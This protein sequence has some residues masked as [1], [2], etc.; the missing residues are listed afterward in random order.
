[1]K[2]I[3]FLRSYSKLLMVALALFLISLPISCTALEIQTG[4]LSLDL[5][6]EKTWTVDFG[7]GDAESLAK[8]GYP[9]NE[10]AL[11]QSLTLD[12]AGDLTPYLSLSANLNDQNPTYLQHFVLSLDTERWDGLLGDFTVGEAEGFTVYNKK[13][14]GLSLER[15]LEN[16][17]VRAIAS[18]MEGVSKSKVF[19]GRSAEEEVTFSLTESDIDW[20]ERPYLQNIRG[21]KYYP[22]S[23]EYVPQLT[24][25]HLELNANQE[26]WTL[27][28]DWGLAYLK[29]AIQ[30]LPAEQLSADRFEVVSHEGTDFL[31]LMEDTEDLL[32]SR[33][34]SYIEEF[35]RGK[36]SDDQKRYPFHEGTDFEKR[37]LSELEAMAQLE[38]GQQTIPLGDYSQERFYYLGQTD[39]QEDSLMLEVYREGSWYQ[40]S[41]LTDFR[42]ELY[43]E[44]GI[45]LCQF[46]SSFFE[47]LETSKLRAS[48]SY[49]V[50][51]DVFMLGFSVTP[52]SDR[53]YLNDEPLKRDVDYSIDYETGTVILFVEVGSD[54]EVK[55]D[56]EQA[57]GGIGTEAEYQRNFYGVSFSSTP[58]ENLSLSVGLFQA[59]DFAPDPL[60]PEAETMP[61]THT[62]AGLEGTFDSGPW[63]ATFKAGGSINRFPSDDNQRRPAPN[64]INEIISFDHQGRE[65]ILFAHQDGFSVKKPSRWDSYGTADGLAGVSVSDVALAG[66]QLIFATNSG[67]TVVDLQSEAPFARASNWRS[68]YD[69]DGIPDPECLALDAG[70]E[71]LWIGTPSG[72]IKGKISELDNQEEWMRVKREELSDT[73]VT[74]VLASD[75]VIWLGTSRGLYSY[76]PEEDR[77]HRYQAAGSREITDLTKGSG[78]EVYASTARGIV[79]AEAGQDSRWVFTERE[80]T[81]LHLDGDSL[82]YGTES[83]FARLGEEKSYGDAKV[84]ALEFA[85]DYLWAGTEARP[86][87][88]DEYELS[89]YR[90]R[91]GELQQLVPERTRI[92]SKDRHHFLNISPADHTKRGPFFTY[93]LSRKIDAGDTKGSFDTSLTIQ[94]PDFSPIGKLERKDQLEWE[95]GFNLSPAEPLEWELSRR[96][97]IDDVYQ[98]QNSVGVV[99]SVGLTYQ[100]FLN[101]TVDFRRKKVE[102]SEEIVSLS[103]TLSR[104]LFQDALGLESELALK[105]I[106]RENTPGSDWYIHSLSSLTADPYE[107]LHLGLNYEYPLV[108]SGLSAGGEKGTWSLEYDGS[109]P[110]LDSF[111]TSLSVSDEGQLQNLTNWDRSPRWENDLQVGLGFEKFGAE[112][113]ELTP[114]L[115]LGWNHLRAKEEV[116]A[117]VGTELDLPQLNLRTDVQ[118]KL[119]LPH[120]SS[121]IQAEDKLSGKLELE[122]NETQLQSVVKYDVSRM[123]V[124]HPSYQP[125]TVFD[126]N[127]ALESDW[128]ITEQLNTTFS[129]STGF[130]SEEGVSY[131]LSN[132][133]SWSP[134]PDLSPTFSVDAEYQGQTGEI[135]GKL[136]GKLSYQFR[137]YWRLSLTT[138]L[139]AGRSELGEPYSSSFGS[140]TLL[141]EF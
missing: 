138:G 44:E 102:A 68:Y 16:S 50:T 123:T 32:R 59:S 104:N 6:V 1:M 35:N 74:E 33:V 82:W 69:T 85:S 106:S 105:S 136:S 66:E 40:V 119:S 81:A 80:V 54:D 10:F 93:G 141:A 88:D 29:E 62:V 55:I 64:V 92:V 11:S 47:D 45:L 98:D 25:P 38:L 89:L 18:R 70:E 90:L 87:E 97:L 71:S 114:Q 120:R 31:L 86:L 112:N 133:L 140:V 26:L 8:D 111:V 57:R 20:R 79:R 24:E 23:G 34:R 72:L 51:D 128:A 99:D 126:G 63:E 96:Y 76:W 78:A 53:V 46:P 134:L 124:S 73:S 84:T 129:F 113:L 22:L 30:K 28:S 43:S 100:G 60:P 95:L 7:F 14:K 125:R 49:Q 131:G 56:Y 4:S 101:S 115:T 109:A 135:T 52:G 39:V 37:F 103:G 21:L 42:T 17:S 121:R 77:L 9:A 13:V 61:N 116:L 122:K 36:S 15:D 48:Y 137:D 130:S 75:D 3:L 139:N 5:G 2:A 67:V 65:F 108:N 27:L 83:G 41:D 19:E 118:R 107:E 58:R 127:V 110:L 12:L 94:N 132:D 117:K 91:D